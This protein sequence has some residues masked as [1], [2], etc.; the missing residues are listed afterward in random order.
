MVSFMPRVFQNFF[1][2]DL[3]YIQPPACSQRGFRFTNKTTKAQRTTGGPERFRNFF[4]FTQLMSG[5]EGTELLL[6]SPITGT[7]FHHI[8]LQLILGAV[9]K[10][11]CI[12]HLCFALL[13]SLLKHIAFVYVQVNHSPVH[14]PTT[15]TCLLTECA[16]HLCSPLEFVHLTAVNFGVKQTWVFILSH[17]G[18]VTLCGGLTSLILVFF[19]CKTTIVT[20]DCQETLEGEIYS[21]S[22]IVYSST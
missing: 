6:L 10:L 19:I 17:T 1:T 3:F 22:H 9:E 20:L 13:Q 11:N 7:F 2:L 8:I 4:R 5:G 18:C 21:T 14:N 16:T 15:P 12:P